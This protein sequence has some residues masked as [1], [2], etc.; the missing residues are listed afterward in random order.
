MQPF[1]PARQTIA[2]C[3]K[4]TLYTS[5]P[6]TSCTKTSHEK[7]RKTNLGP[8]LI[9]IQTSVH[10]PI[11]LPYSSLQPS[12]VFRCRSIRV[13]MR[14]YVRCCHR[15]RLCPRWGCSG[16]KDVVEMEVRSRLSAGFG[17]C[18]L[19]FRFRDDPVQAGYDPSKPENSEC[20]AAEMSLTLILLMP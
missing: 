2:S 18:R 13:R 6:N 11:C 5:H 3:P 12:L 7:C 20:A 4:H 17:D 16:G 8:A 15:G 14:A 19:S 9:P 10:A 1:R